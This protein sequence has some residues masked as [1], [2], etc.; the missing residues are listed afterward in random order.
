M[1]KDRYVILLAYFY[2]VQLVLKYIVN[3]ITLT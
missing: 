3:L 1:E 2:D